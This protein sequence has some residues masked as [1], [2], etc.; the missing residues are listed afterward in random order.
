M[1]SGHT[2]VHAAGQ[3]HPQNAFSSQSDQR[4]SEVE[5]DGLL[6]LLTRWG[7][8]EIQLYSKL[9]RNERTKSQNEVRCNRSYRSEEPGNTSSRTI[10]EVKQR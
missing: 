2:Y 8:D 1:S 4:V 5:R 6:L 3:A 7:A 10:T 9:L